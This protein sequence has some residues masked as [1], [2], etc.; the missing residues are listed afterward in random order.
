MMKKHKS[1]ATA[2]PRYFN[3]QPLKFDATGFP[4]MDSP[5]GY[6]TMQNLPSGEDTVE[7]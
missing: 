6:D 4:M 3:V 1:T 2:A 7:L 5:I